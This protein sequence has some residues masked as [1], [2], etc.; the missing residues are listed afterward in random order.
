MGILRKFNEY[1][2]PTDM[3]ETPEPEMG[4]DMPME[5]EATGDKPY[6]DEGKILAEMLGIDY[7]GG[8]MSYEGKEVMFA[9]ETNSF[10]I[11]GKNTKVKT[12]KEM[13]KYLRSG[14]AP[15][16]QSQIQE[17]RKLRQSNK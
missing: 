6:V 8:R 7:S 14:R 12:A 9:S 2:L 11:N 5:D 10:L 1:H 4:E 13:E 16:S 3:G 15:Q 17:S